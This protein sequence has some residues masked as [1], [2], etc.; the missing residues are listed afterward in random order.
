VV[1]AFKEIQL[2]TLDVN[3]MGKQAVVQS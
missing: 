2:T 1:P 3:P